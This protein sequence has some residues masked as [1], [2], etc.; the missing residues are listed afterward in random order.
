MRLAV[1]IVAPFGQFMRCSTEVAISSDSNTKPIRIIDLFAGAGGLSLG[2]H[3]SHRNYKT[4]LAV[5][6]DRWAA[7]TIYRNIGC[8]VHCGPIQ[9]LSDFPHA[10]VV[11][12]G[13]P[14]Q[15]FSTLGRRREDDPR[16]ELLWDFVRVVR[17]VQPKVFLIENVPRILNAQQF[18]HFMQ[19]AHAD[20]VLKTYNLDYSILN[21]ADYGVP[22]NRSRAFIIGIRDISIPWPPIPSH[23]PKASDMPPHRTVRDAIFDLPFKTDGFAVR[24]DGHGRQHL[25]FGRKPTQESLER[26]R[27]IPPG[28]NRFDLARIRPDLLPNCWAN[29]PKGTTDVMGRMWWDRPAP[30][31]RTEFFK[32]EKGRY[33]H[34]EADRPITHR[35]AARIQTFP[36]TY[37]FSGSN[38][39]IA[40]QIG[41]AVPPILSQAIA[42]HVHGLVFAPGADLPSFHGC[43]GG[44][45]PAEECLFCT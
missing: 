37:I 12:G 3:N 13:P 8:K 18:Q 38:I 44:H 2:F 42:T 22:Q 16:N 6:A 28:G 19:F 21:S 35:E 9:E 26:Y 30:T 15:G 11:I 31:I 10:D 17:D 33:L 34:P 45:Q 25:H 23:G 29:K 36:D 20:S 40:R 32:P 41:N 4:I 39:E 5:E 1:H 43:I 7:E 14:C 27:A 24:V